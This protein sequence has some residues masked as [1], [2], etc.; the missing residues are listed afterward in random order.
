MK[1]WGEGTID[2]FGKSAD[3][4]DAW[5]EKRK[6]KKKRDME[7]DLY[8][9]IGGGKS[10]GKEHKES[11]AVAA[12]IAGTKEAFAAEAKFHNNSIQEP[13]LLEARMTNKKLD[14]VNDTLKSIDSGIK[15]LYKGDD[16]D[17]SF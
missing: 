11:D 17:D 6:N 1:K 2:N 3:Q 16:D 7:E 4:V 13:Q 10:K 5:F 8:D 12:L 14:S 15:S 9:P